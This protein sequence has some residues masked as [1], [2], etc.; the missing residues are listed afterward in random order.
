MQKLSKLLEYKGQGRNSDRT[1]MYGIYINK[2]K[3]GAIPKKM[4]F[5]DYL[6]T[7]IKK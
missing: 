6:Q 5:E 4:R 3:E 7:T 2:K 1:K